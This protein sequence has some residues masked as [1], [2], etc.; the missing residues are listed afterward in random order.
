[1][2][3][4]TV[5]SES[6]D[7]AKSLLSDVFCLAHNADRM[8]YH[9]DPADTG[10]EANDLLISQLRA[11]LCKV[12]WM[13]EVASRHLGVPVGNLA[14]NASAEDWLLPPVSRAPT[15]ANHE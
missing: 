9:F 6:L 5:S 10:S 1:M 13:S 14:R 4:S 3:T 11:I 8:C 15:E 7:L 2:A 12:G